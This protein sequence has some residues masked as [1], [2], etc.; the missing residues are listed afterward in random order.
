[1]ATVM[2]S[3]EKNWIGDPLDNEH[4]WQTL[5]LLQ[6]VEQASS[7]GQL[8]DNWRLQMYL[9]RAYFDGYVRVR[10]M[11]ER[12]N[13]ADAYAALALAPSL[14]AN[15]AMALAQ[16]A[17]ARPMDAITNST[18]GALRT[19]LNALYAA[20]N[21]SIGVTVVQTQ[22][23]K[24]G[25]DTIDTPLN[26]VVFLTTEFAGIAK[27]GNETSKQAAIAALLSWQDPTPGTLYD[28][29]GSNL[30]EDRLHL[31][32]GLG[33]LT[34]PDA[35]FSPFTG[36]EF[37]GGSRLSWMRFSHTYYDNPTKLEYTGLDPLA[38]YELRV[39]YWTDGA[40]GGIAPQTMI[41]NNGTVIHDYLTAPFPMRVL[42]FD[43][44]QQETSSG[45]LTLICH[46]TPGYGFSGR[47]CYM[48]EVWLVPHYTAHVLA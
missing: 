12:R 1:M 26:D 15:N 37:I 8:A 19:R 38:A 36:A 47:V 4:I 22:M 2:Y 5:N 24:F 18:A 34:D 14:G 41:A 16:G 20:I 27:L 42:S 10:L 39:V 35:F 30:Q 23:P 43:I 17:L 9:F 46:S 32:M 44:P 31:D 28:A 21:A 3:L 40:G 7:P 25:L 48:S 11:H 33:Y 45:A 6:T 29:M 13:E